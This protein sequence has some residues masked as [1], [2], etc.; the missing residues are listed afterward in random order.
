[1]DPSASLEDVSISDVNDERT[2]ILNETNKNQ[3]S[4]SNGIKDVEELSPV[5]YDVSVEKLQHLPSEPELQE[6]SHQTNT[7]HNDQEE[8]Y[9]FLRSPVNV[10]IN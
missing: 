9:S 5:I 8:R 1:M 2:S 4:I 7:S 6:I 3:E 10:F